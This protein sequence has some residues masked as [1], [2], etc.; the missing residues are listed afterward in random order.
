[1]V[2]SD[3]GGIPET[4]PEYAGILVKPG[5]VEELA[6]AIETMIVEYS[7]FDPHRISKHAHERYGLKSIGKLLHDIYSTATRK[8]TPR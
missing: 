6:E 8:D 4:V 7:R 1:M 2:A 5:S 3:V